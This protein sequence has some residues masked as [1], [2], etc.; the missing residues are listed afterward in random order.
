MRNILR[1]IYINLISLF[2]SKTE[3]KSKNLYKRDQIKKT[4]NTNY[5]IILMLIVLIII[6]IFISYV[7]FRT[8]SL[9]S[10][11]YYYR[12]NSTV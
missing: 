6:F 5:T 7:F 12:L 4:K 2:S 11:N 8:G 1:I 9:E 3:N 10:T